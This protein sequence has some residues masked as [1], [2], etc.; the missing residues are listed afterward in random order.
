MQNQWKALTPDQKTALFGAET[1]AELDLIYAR[2]AQMKDMPSS[3]SQAVRGLG[4]KEPAKALNDITAIQKLTGEKW[5][6]V[7]PRLQRMV[8]DEVLE[9][10]NRR[11]TPRDVKGA[12]ETWNKFTQNKSVMEK[13]GFSKE[14]IKN[15]NELFE[16]EKR[17]IIGSA[18]EM[19]KILF[20]MELAVSVFGPAMFVG[21]TLVDVAVGLMTGVGTSWPAVMSGVGKLGVAM[22]T[23]TGG[24]W[25]TSALLNSP[26]FVKTLTEGIKLPKMP[27]STM[28]YILE[29]IA[30]GGAFNRDELP[31][32]TPQSIKD[33]MGELYQDV[34][35]IAQKEEGF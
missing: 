3:I 31:P 6:E 11:P 24:K 7:R 12:T 10:N 13:L 32:D 21:N 22:G 35:E 17:A 29:T 8:M 15:L 30:R 33:W 16:I 26:R 14:H 18:D 5:L 25:A 1:A 20:A 34:R 23:I 2:M 28:T 19:G 4:S 27:A 9:L